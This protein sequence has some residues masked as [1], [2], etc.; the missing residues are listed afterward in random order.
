MD[1]SSGND[2]PVG[3]I[4]VLSLFVLKIIADTMKLKRNNWGYVKE[5]TD[6]PEEEGVTDDTKIIDPE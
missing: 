3:F 4:V 1:M 6:G 5:N 2:I